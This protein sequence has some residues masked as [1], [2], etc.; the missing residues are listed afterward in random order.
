MSHKR[1]VLSSGRL[2]RYKYRVLPEGIKLDDYRQNNVILCI[3][4]GKTLSVGKM[5]DLQVIDGQLT[6]VPV[7]DVEDP[8]GAELDRK[9]KKG[10]MNAF[11]IYHEPIS[12]SN[13]PALLLEGQTRATV[14][15]TELLEISA[16]NVPGDAGAIRHALSNDQSIDDIIPMLSLSNNKKENPTN[17]EEILKALGLSA[18]ASEADAV[19]AITQ[20]KSQLSLSLKGAVD[21]LIAQG[22][23][24]GVITADNKLYFEKLA[25]TDFD[26]AKGLIENT[27]LAKKDDKKKE[28]ENLTLSAVLSAIKGGN[29][30]TEDKETFEY[31]S[32]NDP[33]KLNKL[34]IDDP[35]KYKQLVSSS[36]GA[37]G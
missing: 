30:S 33:G 29:A 10:F 25:A 32:K 2:N 20:L 15:E 35:E 6:G 22:E 5:E 36:I 28:P 31:L 11:S 18:E 34:R 8:I 17:M 27:K 12:V 16:V 19:Q 7:F 21:T 3:H 13:D 14:V 9:Y 4:E 26:T 24:K 23:A 1:Y 37:K